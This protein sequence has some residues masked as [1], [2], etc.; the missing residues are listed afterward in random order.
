MNT[1]INK[2]LS[3][4][5]DSTAYM[6]ET[7][8]SSCFDM[9]KL[10][11]AVT[12]SK[13]RKSSI[14]DDT[15][16][17]IKA[18]ISRCYERRCP[19]KF[20]VPFGAYKAWRLNLDFRP[21]WAEVFNLSF[22]MKYAVSL[23]SYYPYGI[24]ISY[25]FSDGIMYFVS[26]IPHEKASRYVLDF[27]C[28]IE[29]FNGLFNDI[30]F[31]LVR[32][33][34]LYAGNEDYYI[35]FLKNFLDNLVY[36]DTKYDEQTKN[37]HIKSAHNNVYIYGEREIAAQKDD[38]REKYYFYSALMTDAVDC[39]KE[40]R[41]YN[42][43]SDRIQLVGVKGPGKSINVGACETSTVHFWVGRGVLKMNKGKLKPYVLPYKNLN[44]TKA[45]H[46][47]REESVTTPFSS[48]SDNYK[49]ILIIED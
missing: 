16:L 2:F 38:T 41:K 1:N 5:I 34:D 6:C 30:S 36:W 46:S 45:T 26:D 27:R 40:R 11:Q 4:L 48:I 31:Q 12:S 32:I 33:N 18:K 7:H 20:S 42:K 10:L 28:L 22:L 8:Y 35:D 13:F 14:S 43:N 37:R 44:D 24:E 9:E 49:S 39:L 19:L 47:Y 3:S 17:D 23:R 15:L 25:T 29:L 21:D